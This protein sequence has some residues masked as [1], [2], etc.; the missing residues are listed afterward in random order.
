MRDKLQRGLAGAVAGAIATA[1]M[2]AVM[3]AA[4]RTGLMGR[5]PPEAIVQKALDAANAQP[6][7]A[8]ARAAAVTAHFAFGAAGGAAYA[9]LD[10]DDDSLPLSIAK[11]V[12]FGL[13]VYAVSY[14]GWIPAMHILPKPARDRKGRQPSMAV[15]HL[16]Y[17]AA[18][19]L[20]LR[21]SRSSH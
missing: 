8:A 5:Q 12:G 21:H 17:G 4:E 3:L 1:P 15:A 7:S 20:L 2:S 11:G 10:D 6:S 19:A 9:F 18:L 16:V 14:A 13:A